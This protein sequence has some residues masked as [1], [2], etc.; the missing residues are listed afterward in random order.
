MLMETILLASLAL[1]T[2]SAEQTP[3][4]GGE[5]R[6]LKMLARGV[7]P[8]RHEK[9]AQLILRNGEELAMAHGVDRKNA[10]QK[11]FQLA[12]MEDVALLLKVRG[13]DWDKQMIVVVAAGAQPTGGYSVEVLSQAVKDG[14]LTVNWRLNKPADGAAVTQAVTYPAQ[15]VLIERFEGPVKFDPPAKEK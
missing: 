13:I 11:R 1:G 7:W 4:R 12:A 10:R 8:V 3:G 5:D 2:A 6:D 14:T 9:P 15:M